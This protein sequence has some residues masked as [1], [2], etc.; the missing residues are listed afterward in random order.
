MREI[1]GALIFALLSYL[2]CAFVGWNLNPAEWSIVWRL[3]SAT[4]LIWWAMIGAAI[5]GL[6]R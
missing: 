6:T 4:A 1:I 5:G 3:I 2:F